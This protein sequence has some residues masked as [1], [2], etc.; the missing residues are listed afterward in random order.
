MTR[1]VR[2]TSILAPTVLYFPTRSVV[3]GSPLIRV[4]SA[5]SCFTLRAPTGAA[6]SLYLRNPFLTM[7]H[8]SDTASP[9]SLSPPRGRDRT[10]FSFFR[11][12]S[13]SQPTLT[14][15]N[16]GGGSTKIVV[17]V[18]LLLLSTISH[19]SSIRPTNCLPLS[20]SIQTKEQQHYNYHAVHSRQ[21]D[22]TSRCR[23]TFR[24][25]HAWI[26]RQGNQVWRRRARGHAQGSQHVG[27]CRRGEFV[28]LERKMGMHVPVTRLLAWLVS[29]A[30]VGPQLDPPTAWPH[31]RR[32]F[33][34]LLPFR[35]LSVANFRRETQ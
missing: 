35:I 15:T 19:S 9:A 21:K 16:H 23:S 17:V 20:R 27:R 12:L 18:R 32:S 8:G 34:I 5:R 28:L 22:G 7:G 29:G 2:R 13:R 6:G 3:F 26:C 4:S 24:G 11:A 25:L 10:L 1:N 31:R 33:E 14:A 30:T